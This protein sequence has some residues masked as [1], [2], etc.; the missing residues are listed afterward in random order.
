MQHYRCIFFKKLFILF[1]NTTLILPFLL[2]I[3]IY[4]KKLTTPYTNSTTILNNLELI[5]VEIN[6]FIIN[7][8][9][10]NII[11]ET[12]YLGNLFLVEVKSKP[13]LFL[14]VDIEIVIERIY[15]II[16]AKTAP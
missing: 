16:A 8:T 11:K 13:Y 7:I 2:F 5:L 14:K 1:P 15:P 12:I 6:N 4:T 9:K 3:I 10:V